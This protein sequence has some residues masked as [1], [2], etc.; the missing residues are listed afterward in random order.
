VFVNKVE[1]VVK[2][3]QE[4]A[5]VQLL[6]E[7]GK[8]GLPSGMTGYYILRDRENPQRFWLLDMWENVEDKD[9]LEATPEYKVFH[10]RRNEMLEK[11]AEKHPCDLVAQG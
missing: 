2:S 3:G 7:Q 4:D 11:P 8:E 9:R 10:S 1:F 5:F 6:Q